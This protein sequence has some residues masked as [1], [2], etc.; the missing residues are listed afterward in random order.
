LTVDGDWASG[1]VRPSTVNGQRPSPTFCEAKASED[2]VG[3]VAG[4]ELAARESRGVAR[5]PD[6]PF[7]VPRAEGAIDD[8]ERVLLDSRHEDPGSVAGLQLEGAVAQDAA[9]ELD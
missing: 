3:P 9:A 1:G 8:L 5:D 4:V 6:R 2:R 7:L